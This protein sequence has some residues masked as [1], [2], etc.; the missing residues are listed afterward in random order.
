MENKITILT[1]VVFCL[2]LLALC[3]LYFLGDRILYSIFDYWRFRGYGHE[4]GIDLGAYSSLVFMTCNLLG[5][6]A[7]VP[8]LLVSRNENNRRLY[9]LSITT[10]MVY[11]LNGILLF[12]IISSG[13]AFLFCGR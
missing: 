6:V 1:L 5:V 9:I 8:I 11:F 12:C 13:L 7:T 10:G 3:G 2:L 4:Q